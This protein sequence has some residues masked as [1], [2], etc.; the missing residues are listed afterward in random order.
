VLIPND[1]PNPTFADRRKRDRVRT[2]EG[3]E[4]CSRKG[5][6]PTFHLEQG[7][8]KKEEK[9]KEANDKNHLTSRLN[10]KQ[11]SQ[12]KTKDRQVPK[13]KER[14]VRFHHRNK[15]HKPRVT[16]YLSPPNTS[17]DPQLPSSFAKTASGRRH[18]ENT[19][20]SFESFAEYHDCFTIVTTLRTTRLN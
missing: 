12:Q 2:N 7:R 19:F 4:G 9:G 6:C 11:N 5:A 3:R 18:S 13:E 15:T 8:E 17:R 14:E 20:T 10:T 16:A 1:H